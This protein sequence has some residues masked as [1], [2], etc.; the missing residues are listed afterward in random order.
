MPFRK[1]TCPHC[2]RMVSVRED[3]I[4]PACCRDT[5][6]AP[7][8]SVGLTPV[9]FVDGERLPPS[10]LICG[11]D[12][13][14][15]VLVGEKDEKETRDSTMV[16][17]RILGLIGGV[18]AIPINPSPPKSEYKI[19]I[20]IPVCERHKNSAVLKPIYVDYEGFR[21]ALPAHREFQNKW[22]RGRTTR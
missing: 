5:S 17:S 2:F 8:E 16:F 3:A 6:Q 18:I 19:S 11:S 10:C 14:Q 13:E 22:K 1:L 15:Y 4:C 9:E 7:A 21:I 20:R 12:C